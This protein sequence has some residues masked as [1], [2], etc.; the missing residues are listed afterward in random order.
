LLLPLSHLSKFLFHVACPSLDAHRSPPMAT[1]V[2]R[3]AMH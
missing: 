1:T 2:I 3:G